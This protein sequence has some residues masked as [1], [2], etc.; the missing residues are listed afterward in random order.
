MSACG[1][2]VGAA[3]VMSPDI[4]SKMLDRRGFDSAAAE[5]AWDIRA[6]HCDV[7]R[8]EV[9]EA[10][11]DQIRRTGRRG[12]RGGEG[13]HMT[14]RHCLRLVTVFHPLCSGDG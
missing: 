10:K 8:S 12:M 2:G 14:C 7:V 6:D 9:V 5:A 11:S 1:R 4:G 3:S 13:W